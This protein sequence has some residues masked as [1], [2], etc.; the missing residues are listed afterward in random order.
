MQKELESKFLS[1]FESNQNIVHKVC[2]IYTTNQNAHNDLFQEIAIQLWK[3][4][5]KFRGD[6]K[7]ST[8][9]YRVALNTAISLYRKS[10]KRVK[11]QDISE[12]TFKIQAHEYDDTEELQLKAL[13]KA[14]QTLNDIDKALIFLYLEDKPY[15]EIAETLGNTK[16]FREIAETLG[17]TEVNARVKMNR[18]K[19]KL[20]K[21]LNP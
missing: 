20:K 4:Y 7:F 21:I 8:W 12:L 6:A 15:R 11:T 9:M 19:D 16:G 1:D 18:A 14:I 13:Y 3:N 10:S 17:I 5:S 2:R